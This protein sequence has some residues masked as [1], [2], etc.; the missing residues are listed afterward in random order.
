MERTINHPGFINVNLGD[1][2][3]LLKLAEAVD[4]KIYTPACLP[5]VDK[6]YTD[7]TSWAYGWGSTKRCPL[8][9]TTILM[10]VSLP[11]LSD[12]VCGQATGTFNTL[13]GGQCVPRQTNY[14]GR[15][16]RWIRW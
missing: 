14:Q 12:E 11:I 13:E 5:S 3:A 8:E 10:E 9:T 16:M 4:L 1:D 6:D 15:I 2:I 7:Q